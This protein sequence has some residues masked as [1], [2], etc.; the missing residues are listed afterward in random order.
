M[1]K[2]LILPSKR[3]RSEILMKIEDIASFLAA[4]SDKKG[5]ETIKP[6]LFSGYAGVAL[7]LF[8]YSRFKKDTCIADVAMNYLE[9]TVTSIESALRHNFCGGI[10]GVCWCILHLIKGEFIIDRENREILDQFDQY[11]ARCALH[12]TALN[13]LD[14]LHGAIGS[15]V[16][17]LSRLRNNFIRNKETQIIDFI[18]SYKVVQTN[19]YTWEYKIG[20]KYNISLSHGMSGTC[21]YLAKAYYHGIHKQKIKDI[22][23]KS[24]QFLLEQEIKTPQLSLFPTFCTSYGDQVSRLGWCYGDIGVALAIWHYAIVVGDKSLRKKAIE[25]F[26]FSSNRRD[27]KANAIIDG[28]ICHGTAGLALIFRRM[29]LYTNIEE[30]KEC[31]EYWLEQTLLIAKYKDGIIGYKFNMNDLSIDLLNGISGI[32]LVL[33]SF[34][35]DDRSQSWDECL[36]LS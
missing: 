23:S 18:D 32:G 29:Y 20:N 17:L 34:L 4:I 13:Y 36:L 9:N 22:L 11:I 35:S 26:L 33:L 24:I 16:Y 7:F 25:I 5:N 6:G 14:Y 21:V 15:A 2:Q 1:K 10:S 30:F 27:L 19:T 8:Y 3:L 12:D 28:S 31:S